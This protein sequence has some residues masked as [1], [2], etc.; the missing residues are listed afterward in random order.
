MIGKTAMAVT[1]VLAA[2]GF[3]FAVA[4]DAAAK[5]RPAKCVMMTAKGSGFGQTLAK[6]FAADALLDNQAQRG[7]KGQGSITY[8]CAEE[9]LT[10][11]TAKQRACAGKKA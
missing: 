1:A 7:M 4:D 11:C 8:K 2:A 5:K 9:G 10:M 3:T 6:G